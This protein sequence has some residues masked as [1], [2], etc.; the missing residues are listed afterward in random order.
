MGVIV[1]TLLIQITIF[2]SSSYS[3]IE[4]LFDYFNLTIN[5]K[6]KCRYYSLQWETY[7]PVRTIAEMMDSKV[8]QNGN[9][10]TATIDDPWLKSIDGKDVIGTRYT[11]DYINNISLFD[12]L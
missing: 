3:N 9:T 10:N 8:G 6:S 7:A 11:V 2:A 4:V 12:S 5:E 1:S